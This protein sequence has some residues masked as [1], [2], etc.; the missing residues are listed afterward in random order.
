MPES[1]YLLLARR[2]EKSSAGGKGVRLSFEAAIHVAQALRAYQAQPTR[3][4]VARAICTTRAC[5][6]LCMTCVSKANAI[7][8]LYG[9]EDGPFDGDPPANSAK[10]LPLTT[11]SRLRVVGSR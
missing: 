2:I 8:R 10:L 6:T 7:H 11:K 4:D 3:D 9:G 1:P 5:P